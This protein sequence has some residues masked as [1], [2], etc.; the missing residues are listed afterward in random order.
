MIRGYLISR[1][2]ILLI[3]IVL[4]FGICFDK[5]RLQGKLYAY[6]IIH[7]ILIEVALFCTEQ[8]KEQQQ[9]QQNQQKNK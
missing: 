5:P 6:I 9:Q 2:R 3:L 7:K 8:V 1:T 4:N